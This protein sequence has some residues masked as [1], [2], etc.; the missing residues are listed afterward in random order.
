MLGEVKEREVTSEPKPLVARHSTG[1]P[2]PKGGAARTLAAPNHGILKRATRLRR[3]RIKQ[4]HMRLS[5]LLRKP[6]GL[7]RE[8]GQ[9]R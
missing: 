3:N 1:F 2:K 8:V 4:I 6:L 5:P 9:A 7:L